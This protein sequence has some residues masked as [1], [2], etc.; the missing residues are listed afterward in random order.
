M[1]NA[2]NLTV[3]HVFKKLI[4]VDLPVCAHP[5]KALAQNC[6]QETA[7]GQSH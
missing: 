5:V 4:A 1:P 7:V 6:S 3:N 2:S